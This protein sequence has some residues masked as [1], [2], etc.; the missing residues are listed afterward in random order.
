MTRKR[1][2]LSVRD[3]HGWQDFALDYFAF[4]DCGIP[5]RPSPTLHK[6][7]FNDRA[8]FLELFARCKDDLAAVIE[9]AGPLISEEEGLGGEPDPEFLAT[10]A[11]A[12]RG[13]GALLVFDEIVTGFRYRQGSV[14]KATGTRPT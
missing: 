2:I 13:A 7:R 12:A 14:Q 5:D 9:P 10:V 11:D 8:G 6:F 1:T 3:F 4:E